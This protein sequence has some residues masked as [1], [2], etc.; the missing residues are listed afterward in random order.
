MAFS[1]E[2]ARKWCR[3]AALHGRINGKPNSYH[4]ADLDWMWMDGETPYSL[5]R[6]KEHFKVFRK[7]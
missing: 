7:A 1:C 4:A 2:Q 6:I 3:R 5:K